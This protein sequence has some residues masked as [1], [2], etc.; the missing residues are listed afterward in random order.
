MVWN[1]SSTMRSER[2]AIALDTPRPSMMKLD[3]RC[4]VLS[5]ALLTV[6]TACAAGD[7]DAASGT[8]TSGTTSDVTT[9]QPSGSAT[10]GDE[11][12]TASNSEADTNAPSGRDTDTD[13]D[14]DTDTDTG[15]GQETGTTIPR[16]AVIVAVGYGLRRARSEDGVTW[17][18][19]VEVDPN[20]GDDENLLRGVGYGNGVF[21]AVGD[22]TLRSLD[23]ITWNEEEDIVDSFLSDVVYLDGVFIAAGGNG[24][25]VRSLDNA[26]TWQD[27]TPYF[28][29]HYRAIAVGN[30]IAVAVGHTYGDTN[31]GLA[32]TTTDGLTWTAEQ[33]GGV[34][35]S[36]HSIVFGNG[37]FVTR[38]DAGGLR[39]SAD[40]EAW[41]VSPQSASDGGRIIFAQGEF[42]F[43]DSGAYWT[44][45]DGVA[46]TSAPAE[47]A[48]GLDG[49]FN[50]QYLTL[51]WPATISVSRILRTGSRSSP[52]E[53]PAWRS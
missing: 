33:I 37:V 16:D 20:G 7:D 41:T 21:V 44:S 31:V 17:T 28:A 42:I 6:P 23:G 38:D 12:A 51:G 50:G 32:S 26:V 9:P 34:Q 4:F 2:I 49:W 15:G 52:Q 8:E 24:V 3:H 10:N 14:A 45:E 25:R 18:D 11:T 46:W 48:R 35:Q 19:F 47:S 5:A 43:A 27:Q 29:G 1:E 13:G 30:G 22:R 53:A 40:G 36:G 39:S